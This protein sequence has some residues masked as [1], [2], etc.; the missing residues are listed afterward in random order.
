MS[1]PNL[2][3]FSA[4]VPPHNAASPQKQ[5]IDEQKLRKAA[6]GIRIHAPVKVVVR[7][8]RQRLR[9]ARMRPTPA[10][11]PS[12]NSACKPFPQR[13]LG[14]AASAWAHNGSRLAL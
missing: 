9:V 1:V 12:T 14:L 6:I 3:Q 5:S 7:D 13:S 11:T 10:T 8:A 4:L 2:T